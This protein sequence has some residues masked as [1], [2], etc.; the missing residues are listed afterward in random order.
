MSSQEQSFT[1]LSLGG[2]EG[3]TRIGGILSIM[4]TLIGGG[5]VG[6]PFFF[7]QVGIYVGILMM[8]AVI[9]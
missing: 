3:L 9:I 6:V 2:D 4:S 5:I 7:Y 8:V 1:A